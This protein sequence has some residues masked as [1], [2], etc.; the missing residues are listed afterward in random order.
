MNIKQS[1]IPNDFDWT[2][3]VKLNPDLKSLNEKQAVF[4][5]LTYGIYE[6][7][8]YTE[9]N[10]EYDKKS[11]IEYENKEYK[12]YKA[13]NNVS[14]IWGKKLNR[15]IVNYNN[16]FD[17]DFNFTRQCYNEF[18]N[19]NINQIMNNITSKNYTGLCCHPKQLFNLFNHN[20]KLFN[21]NDELHILYNEKLYKLSNFIK[22]I[23]TFTY[24]DF[25]GLTIKL[26]ENYSFTSNNL[27]LLV[28]IGNEE[29]STIVFDKILKYYNIEK[30]SIAFCI[31]NKL[32]NKFVPI[33]NEQFKTNTIIYSTNEFGNDITPS[34]LLYDELLK[35]YN[36]DYII[37]LQ[38]KT[39]LQF[40][41]NAIDYLTTK[42]LNNLLLE[43]NTNSSTIGFRYVNYK[44]DSL[45]NKIL[46]TKFSHL[47]RKNCF[48]PGT[49][50]LTTND[51]MI[52]IINFFK[53]NYKD[54]FFQNM[55]D[56]NLLNIHCSYIHFIERL[57]G[58]I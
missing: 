10:L 51:N 30:F 43:K 1:K 54:V 42:S 26:I 29:Y 21:Y 50:F 36:F 56:N 48:V 31:N 52:E 28:Y 4:H 57:F 35:T 24:D 49:I 37:K 3:Y 38:T 14:I 8:C 6:N 2:K 41:D 34:L 17:V 7:R 45:Y 32:I 22:F 5:Y 13:E 25:K 39:D 53:N 27:L 23:N 9:T 15:K 40:L 58:Y 47:M 46:K 16:I 44:S 18:S 55:Y 12:E 11:V 19:F 33:I 20:I